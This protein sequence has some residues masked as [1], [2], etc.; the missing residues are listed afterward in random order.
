MKKQE[1][2]LPPDQYSIDKE[3]DDLFEHGDATPVAYWSK[4]KYP[5]LTAM[6]RVDD[7]TDNCVSE[8]LALMYGGAKHRK[9][10]S[11]GIYNIIHRHAQEW[12]LLEDEPINILQLA[13]DQLTQT[14]RDGILQMDKNERRL[15]EMYSAELRE[16]AGQVYQ[17]ALIIRR[18]EEGSRGYAIGDDKVRRLG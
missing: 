3:V 1:E 5:K 14:G 17:D 2:I 10:I 9:E 6:L 15:L 12:G 13:I 4:I 8:T 7:P 16:V 11:R 18:E